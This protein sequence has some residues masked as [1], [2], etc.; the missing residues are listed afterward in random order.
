MLGVLELED[1]PCQL[2]PDRRGNDDVTVR[3]AVLRPQGAP[4]SVQPL[5]AHGIDDSGLISIDDL[6]FDVAGAIF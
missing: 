3:R 6:V 4:G 5:T 1:P 2:R